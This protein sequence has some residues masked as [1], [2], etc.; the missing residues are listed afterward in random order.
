M[1]PFKTPQEHMLAAEQRRIDT[2]T[3]YLETAKEILDQQFKGRTS[4]VADV[5]AIAGL[6]AT[7]DQNDYLLEI[8]NEIGCSS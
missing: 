7:N 5:I 1:N 6:L 4:T 3:G 2:A 8:S